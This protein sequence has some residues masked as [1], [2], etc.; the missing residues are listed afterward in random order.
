MS[1]ETEDEFQKDLI[2]VFVQ[3]AQEWLQQIHVALDELQQGPPPDRHL[4]L[5]QTIKAG[6][7]N[8]GGSAAMISLSDVE[9]ASF[10]TLPFI[11]AVQ[12]PAAKISANDFIALCK[13]LGHIHAALTRATGVT[14][15][16]ESTTACAESL[17]V[18]ILTSNLLAA[19]HGLQERQVKSGSF[20]RNLIQTV[21]A[22]VEELMK[23]GIGQCNVTSLRE[24]LDRL[25]AGE[26]GFLQFVLQQL[27]SLTDELGRLKNGVEAPGRSPER[28]QAV[29]EQVSQLWS[30][31]Q[32]VNATQAMTFFMG[33]HSFLTV[34]MQQRVV[35]AAKKYEA[36]ESRLFES[37]KTIQGWVETG[38]VERTAIGSVLPN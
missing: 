3:E 28:L 24:L 29:V 9:R 20:H 14:F 35:V 34:V 38:R 16:A 12:D 15:D 4:K 30:A 6:V 27:P 1:V 11:E 13:Q 33:L 19:L 22:Q 37:M 8:L 26:E 17:P 32:Q 7:A 36:V 5:A 31:A 23:N 10:S 25:A 18:T 2:A 21:I